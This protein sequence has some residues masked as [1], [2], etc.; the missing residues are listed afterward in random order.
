M[1]KQKHPMVELLDAGYVSK[2][3]TNEQG[4]YRY[5]SDEAVTRRL[6]VVMVQQE[7]YI[8]KAE[9]KEMH[10]SRFATARGHEM[11]YCVI[12]LAVSLADKDGNQYG[13]YEGVGAGADYGDK[14]PQ[15][16]MTGARKYAMSEAA[17]VAWGDDPEGD[18][19][20]DRASRAVTDQEVK[21]AL[22]ALETATDPATL[23]QIYY[24]IDEAVQRVLT[25]RHQKR[26]NS[27]KER[28]RG[29]GDHQVQR[30]GDESEA[31]PDAEKAAKSG[32]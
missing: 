8:T 7:L 1:A 24:G 4:S 26:L 11:N 17:M 5:A 10:L 32:G 14:A 25:A 29:T 27:I 22:R 6:R 15:K 2:D 21:D 9:V 30:G 31:E 23:T 19:S 16:A 13:P 28:V 18:E 20:I 3:K 12:V